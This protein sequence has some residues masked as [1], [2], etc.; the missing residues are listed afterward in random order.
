MGAT[1]LLEMVK[2]TLEVEVVAVVQQ[3]LQVLKAAPA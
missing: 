2:I 3:L 1:T